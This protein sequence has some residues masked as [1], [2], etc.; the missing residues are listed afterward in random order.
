[1]KL[2]TKEIKEISSWFAELKIFNEAYE[3]QCYPIRVMGRE[4][5]ESPR[6]L[7]F[8][9]KVFDDTLDDWVP[10]R[11]VNGANVSC[12][13]KKIIMFGLML[14]RIKITAFYI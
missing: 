4:V 5:F 3:K 10:V 1:M 11:P 7:V 9:G 6:R 13:A 8:G 14:K 12:F 2:L